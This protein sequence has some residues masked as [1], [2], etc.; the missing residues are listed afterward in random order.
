[1]KHFRRSSATAVGL[2]VCLA[3]AAGAQD[4]TRATT[5]GSGAA[6]VTGI[7]VGF[8]T[9]KEAR[10]PLPYSVVAI[11]SLGRERFTTDS[12]EFVLAGV[13]AGDVTLRVRH[14][15][16]SPIDLHVT[17]H[18]DKRD[19]VRIALAHIAVRLAAM[20]VRG[21]PECKSPGPPSAASDSSFATV[22]DQLRQNAEQYRLLTRK[23]PF[24]FAVERIMSTGQADGTMHI[25][26]IDTLVL[27]SIDEWTYRPG[28]VVTRETRS[29]RFFTRGSLL[30][31][32]PTLASFADDAFLA[33]HC[34]Y[35]GGLETVD[36]T[37]LL[38][39][40]FVTASRIR[41]PDV[42]GSMYLDPVN[43]QIRRA[44]L[45]LSKVPAGVRGLAGL[46]ATTLFGEILPS[47]PVIAAVSSVN[48][49][50]TKGRPTDGAVRAFEDQR[51]IAVTFLKGRPG[52]DAK[53]P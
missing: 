36:G 51:L 28:D 33:N 43:F 29:S 11:P 9:A 1:M 49:F 26:S 32:L 39:V 44:L 5:S 17:V 15:G 14:V 27:R 48:Q 31:N 35:N 45:R 12:G 2:L 4:T 47:V 19:T 52:E 30:F 34:F 40:D 24:N 38:R 10:V 22:F 20:Q 7:I 37:E 42:D 23:Y 46:Q 50:D 6:G 41:E 13:P 18:A 25:E 53:K 8:V 3:S 16:Y 21:Y